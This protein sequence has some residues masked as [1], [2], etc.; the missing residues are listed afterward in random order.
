MS[1][2]TDLVVRILLED[3]GLDQGLKSAEQKIKGFS[4]DTA[5]T[6]AAAGSVAVLGGMA[7]V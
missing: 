4:P 5:A 7:Y 2:A 6:M 1:G 3:D